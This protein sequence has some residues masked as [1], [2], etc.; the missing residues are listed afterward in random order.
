MNRRP[1]S[2]HPLPASKEARHGEIPERLE[3]EKGEGDDSPEQLAP[4]PDGVDPSG[5]PYRADPDV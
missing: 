1:G 5:K 2:G 3:E 4:Q